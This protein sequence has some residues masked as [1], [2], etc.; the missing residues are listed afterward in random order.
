MLSY[1]DFREPLRKWFVINSKNNIRLSENEDGYLKGLK[2][3]QDDVSREESV[4]KEL[5]SL[6]SY[7]NDLGLNN[8]GT[9]E[10]PPV[11]KNKL[12]LEISNGG[13]LVLLM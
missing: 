11:D 8:P 12:D 7:Y 1:L 4:V 3:T 2:E 13:S 9:L 10:M 5:K 6:I